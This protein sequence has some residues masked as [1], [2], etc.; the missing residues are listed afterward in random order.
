MS[1]QGVSWVSLHI[2][3][4]LYT[5]IK[6]KGTLAQKEARR[7][8]LFCVWI[9]NNLVRICSFKVNP[10]EW[11]TQLLL[12]GFVHTT[13]FAPPWDLYLSNIYNIVLCTLESIAKSCFGKLNASFSPLLSF[14]LSLKNH[15]GYCSTYSVFFLYLHAWEWSMVFLLPLQLRH[16]CV[17]FG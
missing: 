6:G 8:C 2:F 11:Q 7:G 14:S 3:N 15:A 4:L 12:W 9:V 5:G 17:S 16:T 10:N 1:N 13:T